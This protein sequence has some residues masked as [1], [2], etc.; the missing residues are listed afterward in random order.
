MGGSVLLPAACCCTA[1]VRRH[2]PRRPRPPGRGVA[3]RA[4]LPPASSQRSATPPL[5]SVAL[6]YLMAAPQC[7]WSQ[8]RSDQQ[9]QQAP[10][11]Q[12]HFMATAVTSLLASSTEYHQYRHH[13][14]HYHHQR[15]QQ[16]VLTASPSDVPFI[17]GFGDRPYLRVWN[18][19]LRVPAAPGTHSCTVAA[20]SAGGVLIGRCS[21]EDGLRRQLRSDSDTVSS[22][23]DVPAANV[24]IDVT[25][26]PMGAS[27]VNVTI[28]T[29][30]LQP[31]W[32]HPVPVAHTT[33][34]VTVA[35]RKDG[36]ASVFL[37]AHRGATS[38]SRLAVG[39]AALPLVPFGAYIYDVDKD[40]NH[41]TSG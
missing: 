24:P 30:T 18:L 13:Y 27:L 3:V 34:M 16:Q 12:H 9:D 19:P 36:L 23:G 15:R 2:Q 8:T 41:S 37:S 35:P 11:P 10:A 4:M 21:C 14:H 17:V 31:Q 20:T 40:G 26:L 5:V 7:C 32:S 22:R 33:V 25:L 29:G 39:T 38:G 28:T 1:A 6:A